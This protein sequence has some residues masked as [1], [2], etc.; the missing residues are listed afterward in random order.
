MKDSKLAFY[1]CLK[2]DQIYCQNDSP[3]NKGDNSLKNKGEKNQDDENFDGT[4]NLFCKTC[5]KHIPRNINHQSQFNDQAQHEIIPK[6]KYEHETDDLN[7]I[8][9]FQKILSLVITSYEKKPDNY[10][11]CVNVRNMVKF[12]KKSLFIE[13]KTSII[14]KNY[15]KEIMEVFDSIEENKKKIFNKLYR[16]NI[17]G[18][19]KIINL[20][21]KQIGDFGL[22]LLCKMD[23]RKLQKL[24][25]ANNNISNIEDL[26][27]LNS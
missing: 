11:N 25:L 9:L 6:E 14:D 1:H 4:L 12:L 13:P 16:T 5:N 19:E 18:N 10:Y 7:L 22:K 23:L 26:K 2:D 21:D 20:R 15:E 8:Y 17:T 27:F 24:I 3:K